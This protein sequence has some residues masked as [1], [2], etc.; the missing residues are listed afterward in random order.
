MNDRS[1]NGLVMKASGRGGPPARSHA[2]QAAPNGRVDNEGRE[3]EMNFP[4]LFRQVEVGQTF[5]ADDG[6]VFVKRAENKRPDLVRFCHDCQEQVGAN[7][8]VK[9]RKID[10]TGWSEFV[11]FCPTDFVRV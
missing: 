1:R 7:A 6:T 2:W 10:D 5:K 11:H 8:I 9:G 3:R 4:A